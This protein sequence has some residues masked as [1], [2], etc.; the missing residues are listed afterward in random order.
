MKK[1]VTESRT[2][3]ARYIIDTIFAIIAFILAAHFI[4]KLF[5]IDNANFLVDFIY[6][7]GSIFIFPFKDIVDNFKIGDNLTFESSTII[8]LVI[9]SLLYWLI[10]GLFTKNKYTVTEEET[11]EFLR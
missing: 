5:E 2:N 9:I 7:V 3:V 6:R 11:T 8:A 1:I 4:L 10:S